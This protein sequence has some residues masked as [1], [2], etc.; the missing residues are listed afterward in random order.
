MDRARVYADGRWMGMPAHHTSPAA[1]KQKGV[2][3]GYLDAE[4]GAGSGANAKGEMDVDSAAPASAPVTSTDTAAKATQGSSPAP[5]TPASSSSSSANEFLPELDI[6]L[7][8][9]VIVHL[10]DQKK[11]DKVGCHPHTLYARH[12]SLPGRL[13]SR[14]LPLDARAQCAEL[15]DATVAR[16]A[17]LNRRTMDQLAAKIYFYYARLH[18]LVGGPAFLSSI[19]PCVLPRPAPLRDTC[20]PRRRPR[21]IPEYILIAVRQLLAAQRLSALRRDDD[22]QATLLNLLLRNY[23]AFNLYDQADKL[24]AKTTFPDSA[25]NPQLARWLYYVGA[26]GLSRPCPTWAGPSLVHVHAWAPLLTPAS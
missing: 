25:G 4:A 5:G 6:Y 23:F 8:L 26:S 1:E 21:L 14:R 10:L 16:L 22:L 7:T 20:S 18:E 17:N 19:R 9:L 15:A 2:L 24:I 11:L 12:A 13:T 3:L